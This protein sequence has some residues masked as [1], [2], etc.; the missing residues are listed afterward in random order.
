MIYKYLDF[1]TEGHDSE[2]SPIYWD[3]QLNEIISKEWIDFSSN[4]YSGDVYF[5]KFKINDGGQ[6][7]FYSVLVDKNR[8]IYLMENSVDKKF[9][10]KFRTEFWKNPAKY[11][12]AFKK[13]KPKCLGDWNQIEMSIK[14]NL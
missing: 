11:A 1:I 7:P 6:Y 10:E 8:E 12:P 13:F 2:K 5:I 9:I 3:S 14:Y 4:R